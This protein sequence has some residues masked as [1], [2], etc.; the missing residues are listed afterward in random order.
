MRC[1]VKLETITRNA[2]GYEVTYVPVT[3]G[4]PENQAFFKY[5][6]YGSI[7]LGIVNDK[8]V[9]G[10]EPGKEYYIEFTEAM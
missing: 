9:A 7:K 10:L 3:T 5:T 4:S 1:K 8:V 6:P 2:S